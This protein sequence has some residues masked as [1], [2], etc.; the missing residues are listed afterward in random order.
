[1]ANFFQD[2]FKK[3]K[4]N[5]E[6]DP[7]QPGELLSAGVEIQKGDARLKGGITIDNLTPSEK[8]SLIRFRQK[9]Q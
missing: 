2:I 8:Q 5:P 4:S 6:S 7:I 1:M 9:N 3:K